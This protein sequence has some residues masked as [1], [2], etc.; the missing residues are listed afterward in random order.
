MVFAP[1]EH[2]TN[3]NT[4][5]PIGHRSGI[6][7]RETIGTATIHT[8]NVYI[9]VGVMLPVESA[10]V[11]DLTSNGVDDIEDVLTSGDATLHLVVRMRVMSGLIGTLGNSGDSIRD[12]HGVVLSYG[13]A[14][15]VRYCS[16]GQ[17]K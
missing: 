5:E 4:M 8:G 6:V 17:N 12:S 10:V 16:N 15:I 3:G 14:V 13:C 1:T 2:L 7:A 11:D 9:V